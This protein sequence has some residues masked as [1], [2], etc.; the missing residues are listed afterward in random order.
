MVNIFAGINRC[1]W[2][3][4]VVVQALKDVQVDV[5]VVIRLGR[6]N[7]VEG[8]RILSGSGLPIICAVTLME[9]A[10]RAVGAWQND[11]NQDTR[12]RLAQ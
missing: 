9:A 6:T 7:V 2:V 8:Q 11:V 10:E 4:E 3:A 1:D 5:P 12:M